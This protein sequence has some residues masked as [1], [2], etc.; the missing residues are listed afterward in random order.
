V[1]YVPP[2]GQIPAPTITGVYG[3]LGGGSQFAIGGSI[4]AQATPGGG[5]A[6]P[7][8]GTTIKVGPEGF[9]YQFAGSGGGLTYGAG[10]GP[11]AFDTHRPDLHRGGGW[12]LLMP[13]GTEDLYNLL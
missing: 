2:P 3:A 9:G 10:F 13:K 12:H 1:G 8:S 11:G 5:K 7:G 6:G 4:G